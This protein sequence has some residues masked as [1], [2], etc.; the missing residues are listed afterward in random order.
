MEKSF[1]PEH[2]RTMSP[3]NRNRMA[4]NSTISL[5]FNI[6]RKPLNLKISKQSDQVDELM[7]V[8]LNACIFCSYTQFQTHSTK[9]QVDCI[10]SAIL[11][12]MR[13]VLDILSELTEM[14]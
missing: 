12:P 10:S 6:E 11:F 7:T 9:V 5:K 14:I 8:R 4:A 13:N 1:R 2:G 3:T